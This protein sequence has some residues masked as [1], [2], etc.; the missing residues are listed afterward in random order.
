MKTWFWF[1]V[2]I[3]SELY[4]PHNSSL[5]ALI[6]SSR[7]DST[8]KHR[9]QGSA[10]REKH[11]H[12]VLFFIDIYNCIFTA[13][14]SELSH[15]FFSQTF[16]HLSN[17]YIFLCTGYQ[18]LNI[19]V[20]AW[21]SLTVLYIHTNR[22]SLTYLEHRSYIR[23]PV[24]NVSQKETQYSGEPLSPLIEYTLYLWPMGF[25]LRAQH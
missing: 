15:H 4:F 17:S 22:I 18:M 16:S 14:L 6:H 13:F 24:Y 25:W 3:V 8:Q 10:K 23:D 19:R 1:W 5:L 21:L 9:A 7:T 20:N 2:Q 12:W 11:K